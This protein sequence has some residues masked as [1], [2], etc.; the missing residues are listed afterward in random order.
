MK[1][2]PKPILISPELAAR[3]DGNDQAE[4][5]DK[6]FRAVLSVPHSA[7]LKDTAKRK[8]SRTRKHLP[9]NGS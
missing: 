2:R 6:L 4:R 7:V 1:S 5:M 9:P 8:R 3:C